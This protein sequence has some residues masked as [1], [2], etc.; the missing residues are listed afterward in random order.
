MIKMFI[1]DEEVVSNKELVI[2]E[3]MLATPSA[4]LNNCYPKSWEDIKDY[5]SKFYYPRDYSRCII[6]Q[7]SFEHGTNRYAKLNVSGIFPTFETNT[8]K[9]F[10]K[11]EIDGK[12]TQETRS[13]KNIFNKNAIGISNGVNKSVLSTGIRTTITVAGQYKYFATKLGGSEL[14]GKTLTFGGTIS[15]SSQNQGSIALYY[16][17]SSSVASSFIAR[18]SATGSRT[19]T[20][21]TE[22]PSGTD[23]VYI[24]FYGNNTGTGNVNDYVDYTDFMVVK[25]STLGTYEDYGVS[26]SPDYPSEVECVKGKNLLLN[27][28]ST[29]TINGVT[30][31]V[32][33]DKTVNVDGTNSST[34]NI[35]FRINTTLTLSAGTYKLSGCPSGGA[36]TTYR[37]AVQDSSW[38]VLAIDTGNGNTFTLSSE[39]TVKVS[40]YIQGSYSANNLLFKPMISLEKGTTSTS[41]LPYNTIQVKNTRINIFDSENWY[42][43]LHNIKPVSMLKET[44]DG[45]EYYKFRPDGIYNFPYMKGQFKENTQYIFSSKAR[46]FDNSDTYSTGIVFVYT[47]GTTTSLFVEKTLE[48]YSY[49]LT[50]APNKTIDY[51]RLNY[52]YN[53]YVLMRDIQLQEG[54]ESTTYEP[55]Q[56]NTLNIDLQGN[57]LC[58]LPNNTKDE[59]VVE[60]GRAKIIKNVGKVVLNG[61]EEW[62]QDRELTNSFRYYTAKIIHGFNNISLSNYFVNKTIGIINSV[63]EQG[64]TVV[65]NRQLATR[66]N[67]SIATTVAEFKTWLTTHNV[68]VYYELATP[69]EIDLGE[70]ETLSTFNGINNVSLDA[71][72]QTN[73]NLT[74]LW[75][76][77]GLLFCGIVKN[78]GNISLNP[79]YAHFGSFQILD[80]KTFLSESDT[81]DFVIS[82]KTIIEAIEMV[83]D[84]ISTYGFILGNIKIFGADDIIGA[85]STQNKTAYDVFQY[86]AEITGSRWFTRLIDEKTIAIDFY[87]P[88][89]MERGDNIEYNEKYFEDNYVVDLSFSYGSR[90]YRNKQVILSDEIYASIDYTEVILSNGYQTTFNTENNIGIIKSIYIDN[91]EKTFATNN[92]KETGIDAEFYYTPGKSSFESDGSTY[93]AGTQITITYTPLV[94]GRQVVYNNDEVARIYAQTGRKGVIAR[95]ESRNDILS[96]KE[97]DKVG[98]SYIKYKGSPEV[99]LTLTTEDKDLYNIGQIVYFDS[100]IPDLAQDYMIKSKQTKIIMI[101]ETSQKIFFIYELTSSFNAEKEIN[102]F[103]NQRNKNKGNISVGETIT[104]NIDIEN[105][106]NII[107]KD[108]TINEASATGN[109]LLNST[110]NSPFVE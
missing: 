53:N 16:G 62:L 20:L 68:I 107:F 87:D 42:E 100:P 34:S 92:E 22:F 94:R 58:S 50:S 35:P 91:I 52:A 63:D 41:Y 13:G 4:I 93:P 75:E 28:L 54:I 32:N 82:N 60:N 66:V 77:Y 9:P 6:G 12:S 73:M 79:R 19:L 36:R 51:I 74:Y 67:K 3:E 71:N 85:Y 83:I 39:T 84:A 104:R 31:T 69:T 15:P 40:I 103:D 45:H 65:N 27:N 1:N 37:L 29:I 80:F 44:I 78:S 86:I 2:K 25:G 38:N 106:A 109:N 56:E 18:I 11:I 72:M 96:S 105:T 99:I 98:Q 21:D 95:Y 47:D 81:L 7:G 23:S 49:Y 24:L 76:N 14:L 17:S 59:L 33:D 46:K 30:A 55:Y 57:E 101:D 89:L 110:L 64:L 88:T 8:E 48:E 97:L 61:S 102:Y 70:V 108:M 10:D 43:T 26:P 90:D 5:V